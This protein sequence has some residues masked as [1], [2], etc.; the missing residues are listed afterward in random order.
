MKK[1]KL[2]AMLLGIVALG[3]ATSCSKDNDTDSGN[4][5]KS[6]IVGKWQQ[7]NGSHIWEFTKDGYYFEDGELEAKYVIKDST[8][9]YYWKDSHGNFTEDINDWNIFTILFLSDTHLTIHEVAKG[10]GEYDV[11][12]GTYGDWE[13]TRDFERI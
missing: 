6:L 12:T 11:D 2:F 5:F 3:L 8:I 10:E 1:L 13:K 7:V 4:R 9:L